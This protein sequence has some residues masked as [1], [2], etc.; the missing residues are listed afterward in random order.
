M[1]ITKYEYSLRMHPHHGRSTAGFFLCGG[2]R[3]ERQ[4]EIREWIG[5][6][7]KVVRA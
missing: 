2:Q 5:M 7:F 4:R 6:Q 1:A 3:E